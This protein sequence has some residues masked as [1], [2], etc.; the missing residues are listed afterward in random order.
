[1]SNGFSKNGAFRHSYAGL[2]KLPENG[3]YRYR[4]NPDPKTEEWI[5]AG[6]IK[7]KKILTQKEIKN[8]VKKSG[9]EPQKVEN[10]SFVEIEDKVIEKMCREIDSSKDLEKLIKGE[11]PW[12]ETLI[13]RLDEVVKL[14]EKEEILKLKSL[15]SAK[16]GKDSNEFLCFLR[17]N[18]KDYYA[19]SYSRTFESKKQKETI[20]RGY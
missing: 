6:K 4:T 16:F 9:K 5:I 3:S 20:E 12:E 13:E 1:M 11:K 8:L 10:G 2:Q 15:W 18:V 7:V 19:R 14:L 17:T